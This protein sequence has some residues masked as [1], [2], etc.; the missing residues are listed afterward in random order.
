[1]SYILDALR[2]AERERQLRRVPSLET[3]HASRQP[4]S[5]RAWMWL[6]A[7]ALVVH[8]AVLGVLLWPPGVPV[9]LAP[10]AAVPASRPALEAPRGEAPGGVSG[11]P[12]PVTAAATESATQ[13]E[14]AAPA[15]SSPA[16]AAV[17]PAS[18]GPGAVSGSVKAAREERNPSLGSPPPSDAA[19]R[20]ASEPVST[21]AT[22]GREESPGP[23]VS[24][25]SAPPAEGVPAPAPPEDAKPL[26][27][28]VGTPRE[29]SPVAP[30]PAPPGA[31]GQSPAAALRGLFGPGATAPTPAKP[32]S[33]SP[34]S[35]GPGPSPA[36][37]DAVA[38]MNLDVLVYSERDEDRFVFINGQKYVEGQ[39][40]DGKFVVEGITR[41]GVSLTHLG[42]RFV[43]RPKS[44]PYLKT[45]P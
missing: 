43:L 14:P 24:P 44:N 29:T 23:V 34:A 19:T 3:A 32:E 36:L 16:V 21:P 40:V 13:R 20:L 6:L 1:M 42:E 8:A 11:A 10:S 37:R 35:A 38:R 12:P 31:A 25:P 26:A 45:T 7:G 17:G 4:S 39:S 33:S 2:R 15:R 5:R 28:P 41:E 27:D 18:P 30:A 9:A 22:P